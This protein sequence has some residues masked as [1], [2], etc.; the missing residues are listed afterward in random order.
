MIHTLEQ[1]QELIDN[2][3]SE[4]V[5]LYGVNGRK[6]INKIDSSKY[7]FLPAGGYYIPNY[8]YVGSYGWYWFNMIYRST[9]DSSSSYMLYFANGT[10]ML[11]FLSRTY[12]MT[13][14]P[15]A[16]PRPW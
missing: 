15:V 3:T 14:R 11:G 7:I 12:G 16:P 1:G 10:T 8:D 2:T 9:S 6:Y 13:I 4:W 5:S